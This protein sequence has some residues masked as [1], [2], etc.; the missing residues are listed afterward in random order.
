MS[1]IFKNW[2]PSTK[3]LK[4]TKYI[5]TFTEKNSTNSSYQCINW[6]KW[7][8]FSGRVVGDASSLLLFDKSTSLSKRRAI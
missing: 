1:Q 8:E 5:D 6:N 7:C 2:I 3:E 4:H